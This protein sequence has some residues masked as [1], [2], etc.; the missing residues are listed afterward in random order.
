[1]NP[2]FEWDAEKERVNLAKHGILFEE[3]LTIFSDPLAQ[4]LLDSEHSRGEVREIAIGRSV[5]QRLLVV[6]YT[7]RGSSIR[8]ISARRATRSEVRAYEG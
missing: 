6:V 8:I 3:A 7:L 2:A 5:E 1:M 4:Y